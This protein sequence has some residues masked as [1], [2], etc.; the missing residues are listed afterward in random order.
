MTGNGERHLFQIFRAGTHVDSAGRTLTFGEDDIAR[1]AAS[2]G[3][4]A[5]PLCLG[6][7]SNDRPSYGQVDRLLAIGGN[8]LAAASVNFDLADAVRAGRYKKLSASF[9][10]P[11][12]VGNPAPG[13]YYLKHVG[14]LGAAPPA[15]KDLPALQFAGAT[16]AF[17]TALDA[18]PRFDPVGALS[19]LDEAEAIRGA[20]TQFAERERAAGRDID[21]TSAVLTAVRDGALMATHRHAVRFRQS[22]SMLTY[23]EA[24]ELA[25]RASR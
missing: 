4:R 13:M 21:W 2:Y 7:P 14:F 10:T 11:A 18:A 3:V 5:A 22:C 19:G 15:I 24:V 8:L 12:A 20:A 9:Y 17:A 16:V 23:S 25:E 6:H 1:T